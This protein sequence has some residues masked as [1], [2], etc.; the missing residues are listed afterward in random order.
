MGGSSDPESLTEGHGGRM[1]DEVM[2]IYPIHRTAV[3][4]SMVSFPPALLQVIE[5]FKFNMCVCVYS[6]L[7][8]FKN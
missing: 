5:M 7:W 6:G 2:V 3:S 1:E 8:D 4:S